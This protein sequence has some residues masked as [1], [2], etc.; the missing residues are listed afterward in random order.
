MSYPFGLALSLA[1]AL[2]IAARAQDSLCRPEVSAAAEREARSAMSAREYRLAEQRFQDAFDA[3]P[4]NR[5]ILLGLAQAQVL[6]RE[7]DKAI[8]TALRYLASDRRSVEGRMILANAYLMS[9]RP[10]DALAAAEQ[11]L[12]DH[13]EQAEALK[14]RG[15]AAYLLGDTGKAKDT[16]IK[17][18]DRYPADEDGAYMLGRIYYQGGYLDLAIGQFSRV[19]RINPG[20][21]KALDNLGLCYQGLGDDDKAMRY[22]LTAI[23]LVE[24][25]HP[26]Y[27]WPYTNVAELLL[28]NGDAERAFAAAA[29]ATNRNPMSGRGFYV[30]A[31][32]LE[33]LGKTELSLNW[34]QRSVAVDP[35]SSESWYKLSVLYR[36]LQQND[37]AEEALRKFRELKAKEPA[38]RR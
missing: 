27:E 28:R 2:A 31:K 34:L 29:K 6:G 17:L 15:N 32:A 33:Q 14:I 13:P 21:Y 7:F 18:L 37:K 1:V 38:E 11:V 22:F 35:A 19:L 24:K 36:K 25:D 16:F 4:D 9:Q 20:S 30:G 8:G 3:C 26:E 12:L 5:Q 23:K 10:K